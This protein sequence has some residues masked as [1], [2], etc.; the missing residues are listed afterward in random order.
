MRYITGFFRF[1]Y[2]FLIGD[3]WQIAAGVVLVIGVTRLL[4][5]AM[6]P[7]ASMAGPAFF[8]AL[9]AVFC[10]VVLNEQKKPNARH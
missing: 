6:P 9:L 2:D 5:R 10:G 8:L 1:W 3:S 4:I 7:L